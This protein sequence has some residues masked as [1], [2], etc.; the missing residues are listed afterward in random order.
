[1]SVVIEIVDEAFDIR[2]GRTQRTVVVPQRVRRARAVGA[3]SFSTRSLWGMVTLA[4]M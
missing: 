3:V 2:I 1:M 4:P